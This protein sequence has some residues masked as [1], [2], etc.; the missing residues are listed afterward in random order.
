[1]KEKKAKGIC[2]EG[3][4]RG[5]MISKLPDS[6][7]SRILLYLPTKEVVR[8]SVLSNKWK[9]VWLLVPEL[10]LDSS[11]FPDY[12]AFV[13]FMDRFLD[14]YREEKSCLDKLELRIR[15]D[16]ND[17]SC[18]TRWIDFV[19]THKVKRLDV[20][21]LYVHRKCFEVMPV[22]LYVCETLLYLRLNRVFV[23]SFESVSL[24]RLK[25][26]SLEKNLYA[27]ATGLESLILSCP[28]LEDLSIIRRLDDNVKVLRVLSQ[29]ITTLRVGF[30]RSGDHGFFYFNWETLALFIDAPRL[31]YM[32][33][34]NERS[35]NQFIRNLGSLVKVNFVGDFMLYYND[36]VAISKHQ[37]VHRFLTGISRVR[38]LI[39]SETT[40]ELINTYLKV[41]EPLPQFCNL[42]SLEAE[43][44]LKT[45]EILEILP[46][47]LE[48]F[49]NLKSIVLGL[50]YSMVK[51]KQM[52]VS[53][54]PQCLLSSLEFVDIKSQCQAELV[55]MELAKY[56]AENSAILKKLVLSWKGSNSILEE[57]SVLR[58]LL[59]LLKQ[60]STCQIEVCG[61][62]KRLVSGL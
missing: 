23:G 8:T 20:E 11:E 3:S 4:A 2:H 61:P 6:L 45:V 28:V 41:V 19:A 15:K 32:N 56:F 50:T 21:Y 36:R 44:R 39:I 18:V 5:D 25:T 52:T 51:T 46:T 29:T 38:D 49:P 60:P 22:S 17:Q 55:A 1:M 58:D 14:F 30:D 26:M 24:P 33:F 53:S 27:N 13:S 10:G 12:N 31:K 42:S 40:M 62:L 7:I 59:A 9:S 37:M 47:L 57:D 16:K 35:P 54:M 43:V 34:E 48:S